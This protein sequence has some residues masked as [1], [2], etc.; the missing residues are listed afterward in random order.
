MKPRFPILLIIA[1]TL[2]TLGCAS[3]WQ[4]A[5]NEPAATP[6]KLFEAAE[7]K[8]KKK[9]YREA[10]ES[11]ERLKSAHPDFEKIQ[12]VHQKIGD[13]FF[14]LGEYEDAV[15]RY[16]QFLDL[17]P[18][19]ENRRRV[20]YMIGMCFFNRIKGVD[21]DDSMVKKAEAALRQSAEDPDGGEWKT[22]AQEKHR[23]CRRKLGEK[24]LYKARSYLSM[25]RYAAARIAA[26]RV[27]DDYSDLGLDKEAKELVAKTAGKE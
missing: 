17:Y 24:E 20:R 15:S 2:L 8:F 4:K 1:A 3:V 19:N 9:D 23:E 6:E 12:E 27:L 22:K 25:K 26:Q 18:N 5:A 21:L 14:E 11:F 16:Y 13:A 10:I 7:E